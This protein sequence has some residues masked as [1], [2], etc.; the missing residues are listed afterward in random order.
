MDE[1]VFE[2]A[3]S[4]AKMIREKQ[5]SSEEVVDAH[6]RRI[7]EVNPALNAVVV[8][9]AERAL[10]EARAADSA[11]AK[12]NYK[13]RLHGV[14]MTIKDAL[15]TAGVVSTGGT[16]GRAS[17]VPE[18]D[19]TVVA[20]LRGAG[21]ILLGKT[22]LPELS[23]AGESDNLIYGRTNNPYDLSR[24]PGGSSGGEAAIIASGGSPFGIGSDSGGSIRQPAHYC[25][26]A[27]IK[28]NTGRV[29]ATGHFPRSDGLQKPMWGIG[30]LARSVEDLSLVL[31]VIAGVDGVDPGVVPMS[32]GDADE[33]DVSHLRVSFHTDVGDVKPTAETSAAIRDAASAL[34][35]AGMRVEEDMPEALNETMEF[36]AGLFGADGG[37]AIRAVLESV[38]TTEVHPFIENELAY[39][40]DSSTSIAELTAMMVRWDEYRSSMLAFMGDYDVILCPVHGY[41][42]IPHGT[43]QTVHRFTELYTMAYNL[44][45]WPGAVVRGG[46][47]AEGLP[48]GVQVVAGPW[49]EDVALAVARRIEMDL[50]GWRPPP[51]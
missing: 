42:A 18:Q 6:L 16:K 17:F 34:A 19:A 24:T 47:S 49:R 50:G 51:L 32:L 15:E 9:T 11:L 20:R 1:L 13:G 7:E 41:P 27:G 37:A 8:V 4:L 2:S 3:T 30:P 39:E 35:D 38:G 5:V 40:G 48:I 33:V 26:I 12:G 43:Y 44:T 28:P 29:P 25:G 46:T 45:G 10:S 36:G 23:L 21:A 22:N 31:A 14:P